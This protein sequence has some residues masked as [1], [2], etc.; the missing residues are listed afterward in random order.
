MRSEKELC[1]IVYNNTDK[2]RTGLCHLLTDLLYSNVITS[3]EFCFLDRFLPQNFPKT[4]KESGYSLHYKFTK[5]HGYIWKRGHKASRKRF[6]K[7]LIS[8]L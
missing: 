6:L 2:L 4:W 8:K 5:G 7:R 3:E 1:T